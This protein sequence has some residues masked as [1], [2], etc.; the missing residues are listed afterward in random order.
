V[1]VKPEEKAHVA[2]A[3]VKDLKTRPPARYSEATLLSAMEGAGKSVEDDEFREA[4]KEKGLGTPATRSSII[5]GLI[6]E[7]YMLREGRELIPTAKAF[8]LMTLLRG[9]GVDE[10]SRAELTGEW[11]HK[12][13]QM[14]QGLMSRASF[15]AEITSMTERMVR[16]AKEYDGDTIPGDYATLQTPCPNCGGVV[17]ENYRRYTCTGSASG[18]EGCGFSMT[19]TPAGRAFELTEVESFLSNKQIGPLEGFRSKAGWPFT[20]ELALKW[21]DDDKN[22]KLEFDFGNDA[23]ADTGELIDFTGQTALGQ[24]PSCS[25]AVFDHGSVYACEKA[26]PTAAQPTPSCKFKTGKIVLQQPVDTE[27]IQKLLTTG[28]TDLLDKFVSMRTRR[29]FKAFLAW[30]PEED[31][32]AFEFEPRVSKFPPRKTAAPAK[33]A[34]KKAVAKKAPAK[35]AP[36]KKAPA[37]KAAAKKTVAKKAAAKK[38]AS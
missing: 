2:E 25:S 26:V 30:N 12:L 32:V 36:A 23:N 7:K 21:S 6:A 13:S 17:K 11:E 15:M 3:L 31:K 20:A 37:K 19:K 29:P 18:A 24:C 5:E 10:L 35:K 8:Q 27:Q 14:E 9:L 4:M 38:T 28:K 1:A 33:T 22:W 16:K 34:A